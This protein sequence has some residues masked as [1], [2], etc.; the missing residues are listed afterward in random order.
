MAVRKRKYLFFLL[1]FLLSFTA[2]CAR[3]PRRISPGPS[4]VSVLS[5]PVAG[6]FYHT[7]QRGETFYHIAKIYRVDIHD[8]MRANG[9]A[10]PS[11]LVV[12]QKLYIPG[13]VAVGPSMTAA[14][15]VTI[16]D[17]RRL[18]GP[19]NYSS[20][21]RTIT[22]HHSGTLQGS[23]RSFHHDHLRR[24]M[25]GLF[26]HFVIGNGTSTPDGA[27][28]VGWRWKK[29]VP[30]NRPYDI[31]ICLVGDFDRQDVSDKQFTTLVY[32]ITAL[33]DEYGISISNVRRHNDIKGKHTDCPGKRFPFQRLISVLAQNRS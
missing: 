23:A 18:L 10:N 31:Q 6:G 25:G 20:G 15:P 5:S 1:A 9:Y 33:R 28:E 27:I 30:A 16:E 32:L 13:M 2:G 7:V 11:R 12:G 17:V 19:K 29:Q 14:A 24:R 3:A 26:Y 22:V 21:W 8:V 4:S